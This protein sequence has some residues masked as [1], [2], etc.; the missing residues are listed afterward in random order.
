MNAVLR[1][2]PQEPAL[3]VA[4]SRDFRSYHAFLRAARNY[5]EGPLVAEMYTRYESA[6]G[7]PPA[8]RDLETAED[9]L[10]E[11]L[12]FQVYSWAFRHLQ[13]FKYHRPSF[14]IFATVQAQRDALI[15]RLDASTASAPAD[16]LRLD[17]N[18]DLPAYF[19]Y[20]PFHQHTGGVT[21]DELDG[22]AYEIGRRTTVPSHGDPNG[23]YHL[24]FDT[25][26]KKSYARVLDWGVGHG[27]ALITWQQMHPESE[28]H[29]V[30]LS[31]PCLKLAH[32]RAREHRMRLLLSQ[33]DLEHLDFPDNHFDLIF[34]NFML[35]E[36]PPAN[37]PALLREAH[38]VLKPAGL[39]AGHEF[40]VRPGDAFQNVLQRSHA[41]LNNE[42][43]SVPWY[44]TP[45][46]AIARDVGFKRASIT[47]FERLNRSVLRPGK[48][49]VNANHWNLYQFEK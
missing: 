31:A 6:A 1:E 40:H 5:M 17:P 41:W 10:D 21:H 33:Q 9:M 48:Q 4:E 18:L 7:P 24:L 8:A 30:D 12:P 32:Q 14:G 3:K 19:K 43:Y 46:D 35:H 23:I 2:P 47:P 38:R 37:T 20:V 36:L 34:F 27:A 29:G 15:A 11:L 16:E 28:C 39:F 25:L 49:A 42:T 44:D 22:I 45:I 13:R 26:P